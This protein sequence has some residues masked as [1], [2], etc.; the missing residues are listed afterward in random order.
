[1][2]TF[3]NLHLCLTF[4]SCRIEIHVTINICD[5]NDQCPMF[6]AN[7][8]HSATVAEVRMSLC[9]CTVHERC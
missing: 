3:R 8:P 9:V 4:V 6:D 7:I 2:F 1:M 5:D